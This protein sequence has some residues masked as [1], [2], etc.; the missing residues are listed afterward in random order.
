VPPPTSVW[1]SYP[2]WSP[3]PSKPKPSYPPSTP[4]PCNFRCPQ[5]DLAKNPLTDEAFRDSH[6]FCSYSTPHCKTCSFCEYSTVRQQA[7]NCFRMSLIRLD[8]KLASFCRITTMAIVPRL[9]QLPVLGTAAML[10]APIV[11]SLQTFID[12]RYCEALC[13]WTFLFRITFRL[14]CFRFDQLIYFVPSTFLNF[15]TTIAYIHPNH[16]VQPSGGAKYT[17][18]TGGFF[19]DFFQTGLRK[20]SALPSIFTGSLIQHNP[21]KRD[22]F[23]SMFTFHEPDSKT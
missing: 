21:E 23:V 13:Y 7:D 10:E 18:T 2:S 8:R 9:R 15:C 22:A 12:I 19:L 14:L 6:L 16:R 4:Q 11:R 17:R 1:P 3:S 20:L 5:Q